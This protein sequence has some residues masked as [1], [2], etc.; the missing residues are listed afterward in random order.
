MS[1]LSVTAT[2]IWD[3]FIYNEKSLFWFTVSI[4]SEW[5]FGPEEMQKIMPEGS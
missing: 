3:R 5:S 2:N 4:V 1:Q